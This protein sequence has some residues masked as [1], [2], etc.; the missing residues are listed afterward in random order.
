MDVDLYLYICTGTGTIYKEY[1]YSMG[2]V[3]AST[4]FPNHRPAVQLRRLRRLTTYSTTANFVCIM[5][6]YIMEDVYS[7]T[8]VRMTLPLSD[9]HLFYRHLGPT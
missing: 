7:N 4:V 2:T 1:R 9:V 5:G 3:L 8:A 6:T